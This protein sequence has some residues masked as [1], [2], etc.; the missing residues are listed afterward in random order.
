M[1]KGGYR[2]GA[3]RKAGSAN[4]KTREIADKALQAG[5]TP[6]EYML[7]VLRSETST[8]E[9]KAWAAE[10]AAPY[11]H[12]RLQTTTVKGEGKDGSIPIRGVVELVRPS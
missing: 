10:K 7:N 2:E 3:G 1:A 12:P 5:V 4:K 6:L 11:V 9:Q 8:P